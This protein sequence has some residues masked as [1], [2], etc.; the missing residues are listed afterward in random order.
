[1]NAERSTR[2]FGWRGRSGALALSALVLA[3][4]CTMLLLASR[5]RLGLG[6]GQSVGVQVY[7]ARIETFHLD[8]RHAAQ[9][10]S[11]SS[12]AVAHPRAAPDGETAALAQML[13]CFGPH[14]NEHPE[15]LSMRAG[16]DAHPTQI[17]PWGHSDRDVLPNL[18]NV[19]SPGE[20]MTIVPPGKCA[21]VEGGSGASIGVCAQLPDPPPPSRT[22]EEICVD[23]NMGGPCHPPI[24]DA[25]QQVRRT[26][27]T[28]P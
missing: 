24:P 8:D 11:A 21:P 15:C 22:A 14:R 23:A 25:P 6:G 28:P 16:P 13:V 27:S 10:A 3:A 4:L 2:S 19:Y 20:L 1:V 18:R 26:P 9:R 5:Q 7:V 12:S 17:N